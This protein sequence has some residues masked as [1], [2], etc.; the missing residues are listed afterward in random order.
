MASILGSL[1]VFLKLDSRQFNRGMKKTKSSLTKFEKI[2]GMVTKAVASA[3]A[4]AVVLTG[5]AFFQLE[6]SMT[7]SLA[8]MRDVSAGMREELSNTARIISTKSLFST[9]EL[10]EGYFFLFS[11]GKKVEQAQKLLGTVATFAQAGMFDLA[12]ATTLLSDAQK[13]LGLST[14]DVIEDQKNMTRVADVLVKANTMANA[15]VEQFSMALTTDAGPAMKAFNIELEEGVAVLA[16]YADQG[17]KS[18]KAGSMFGRF[19]RLLI[20]AAN[21]NAEA[22]KELNISVFNAE[23]NLRRMADIVKD[24]EIS[25]K[26]LSVS[27]KS[28]ALE[29]LGFAKKMQ[30]AV[31]PVIGASKT[32]R[33]YE[34]TL[35]NAAGTTQ[36]VS[37]KQLKSFGSQLKIS[38][39]I[40]QEI[41]GSLLSLDS[42]LSGT[43]E[44]LGR[45]N[46]FLGDNIGAVRKVGASFGFVVDIISTNLNDLLSNFMVLIKW[47]PQTVGKL[48]MNIAAIFKSLFKDLM[49]NFE[50]FG[51]ALVNFITDPFSGFKFKLAE[52]NIRET[53]KNIGVKSPEFIQ[54]KYP[55][56]F[57]EFKKIDEQI[58][59]NKSKALS[60]AQKIDAKVAPGKTGGTVRAPAEQT[61]V[62]AVERGSLEALRIQSKRGAKEDKIEKN[63]K[64]TAD[65]ITEMVDIMTKFF[66]AGGMEDKAVIKG[67]FA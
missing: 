23:G 40:T 30:G 41:I 12:Q 11:A 25:F 65:G 29:A 22:F 35:K 38:W 39:N 42:V 21:S 62:K 32:I 3:V 17:I 64:K 10:A 4:A 7:R 34:E 54:F 48:A 59:K 55:N 24:M 50:N 15:S 63:T 49:Q 56:L 31:F 51:E 33:K 6:N 67:V 18:E 53:F 66:P 1:A 45:I 46:S 2:T 28:A 19:L 13:T 37:D 8:I 14:E 26:D 9:K 52:E 58:E 5:K 43:G 60:A 57:D 20:P 47:V 61:I 16:A 44:V 36:E 27:E